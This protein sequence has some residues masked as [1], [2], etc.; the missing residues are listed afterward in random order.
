[1]IPEKPGS[2]KSRQTNIKTYMTPAAT[3]FIHKGQESD[4][5]IVPLCSVISSPLR[6]SS[7]P[8]RKLMALL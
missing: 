3:L 4:I 1:M 5:G 6:S 2:Y 8:T 7:S